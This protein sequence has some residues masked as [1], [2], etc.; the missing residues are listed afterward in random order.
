MDS[1]QKLAHDDRIGRQQGTSPADHQNGVIQLFRRVCYARLDVLRLKVGII[2]QDLSFGHPGGQ[3]VQHVLNTDA[4]CPDAGPPATL[5]R[6]ERDSIAKFHAQIISTG[7]AFH[8]P[9][10][11][12]P[13][14]QLQYIVCDVLYATLR[15]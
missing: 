2:G 15:L 7:P 9:D 5:S 10:F 4:H 8:K 13:F 11:P 6:V 1:R 3:Q 14:S 12:S